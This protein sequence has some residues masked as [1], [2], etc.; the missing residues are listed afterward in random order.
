M[1]TVYTAKAISKG[2]RSG[3]VRTSDGIIDMELRAPAEMGGEKG[4]ANPE[5]LFAAGYSACFNSAAE[6]AAR[7]MRLDGAA[8]IEIE[9]EVGIGQDT[10][11]GGFGLSARITGVFPESISDD[12]A[13]KIMD[14]AHELCPYSR[15]V[16]GNIDVALDVRRK[17]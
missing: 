4:F 15:A 5:D 10:D 7:R 8:D 2:G 13:H 12:D 16:R 17:H 9:V 6:L 11:R 14:A 1:E 3:H